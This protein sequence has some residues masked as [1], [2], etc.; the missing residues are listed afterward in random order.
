VLDLEAR[1]ADLLGELVPLV[2]GVVAGF[3]EGLGVAEDELLD[4]DE[5]GAGL[6]EG[7]ERGRGRRRREAAV[8]LSEELVDE[9]HVGYLNVCF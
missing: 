3:V 9:T 2:L 1:P 6:V 4:V 7:G 8:V 5:A